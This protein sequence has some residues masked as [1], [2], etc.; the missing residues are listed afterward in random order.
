MQRYRYSVTN[1]MSF[2]KEINATKRQGKVD[3]VEKTI[4]GL[5]V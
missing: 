4:D 3:A 2:I 5:K 1:A